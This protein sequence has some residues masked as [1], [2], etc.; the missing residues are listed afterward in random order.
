MN[1]EEKE[2]K[3]KI[4]FETSI[5]CPHC[6]GKI[7]V[8]KTKKRISDPV[9]ADYEEDLIVEKDTQTTLNEVE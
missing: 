7:H 3:P 2:S 1:E 6:K 5:E 4:V 9:P 8:K